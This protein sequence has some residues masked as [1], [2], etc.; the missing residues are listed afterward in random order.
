MRFSWKSLL[1]KKPLGAN[2]KTRRPLFSFEIFFVQAM[3]TI[4]VPGP[5][6]IESISLGMSNLA[7]HVSGDEYFL[8]HCWYAGTAEAWIAAFF[9]GYNIISENEYRQFRKK[10]DAIVKGQPVA[11]PLTD[12][13]TEPIENHPALG[14]Y[15]LTDLISNFF[16]CDAAGKIQLKKYSRTGDDYHHVIWDPQKRI[17]TLVDQVWEA[18]QSGKLELGGETFA[19]F[20]QQYSTIGDRI[21]ILPKLT[22]GTVHYEKQQILPYASD[23]IL[24]ADTEAG[25]NKK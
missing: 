16:T 1:L 10:L 17:Q 23:I 6:G 24:A 13:M 14:T 11:V 20:I 7:F 22:I 9:R 12:M 5:D 4:L 8:I 21:F 18:I 15:R 25:K 2:V 19:A 3:A